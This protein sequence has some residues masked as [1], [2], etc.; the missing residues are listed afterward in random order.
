MMPMILESCPA[1]A[2]AWDKHR[3]F[4]EGEEAGIYNDLA[5]FATFI[6]N[7]YEQGNIHLMT[8]AFAIIEEFFASGDQE[9]RDAAGIGFLEDVRNIASWRSF[10]SAAFVPWL[11]PL[12]KVAWSEIETMWRGKRSLADVVRAEQSKKKQ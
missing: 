9:V 12:S 5:E 2:A 8:A 1:F 10:G 3:E 6:V 4:W 11:G 7:A